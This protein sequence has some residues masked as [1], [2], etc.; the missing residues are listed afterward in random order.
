MRVILVQTTLFGF[1]GAL[2]SLLN[3]HQHFALPALGRLSGQEHRVLTAVALAWGPGLQQR[4]LLL[5]RSRV[6]FMP[7]TDTQI[8]AY[9]RGGQ[10]MGK[11]GAYAIQS[12]AAAWIEAIQGSYSGIMGLPLF[13][14]ASLDF[15]FSGTGDA[16][17]RLR[18]E[19][20]R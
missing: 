14:P 19:L 10:P 8:T 6:R 17:A 16:L 4:R 9:V 1:S 3:A 7:L 13:T 11:A 2:G 20:A 12:E 5:S 15:D 18:T